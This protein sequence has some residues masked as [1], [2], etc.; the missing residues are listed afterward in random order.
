MGGKF[1]TVIFCCF[2][3]VCHFMTTAAPPRRFGEEAAG[4]A[5]Y[6]Q[7]LPEMIIWIFNKSYLFYVPF[8]SRFYL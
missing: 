6:V 8:H 4:A 3:G 7:E 5:Q 1:I 2:G